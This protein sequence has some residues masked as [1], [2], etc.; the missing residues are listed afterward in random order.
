[1]RPPRSRAELTRVRPHA[2][3]FFP[4]WLD[5]VLPTPTQSLTLAELEESITRGG[6][7]LVESQKLSRLP[8]CFVAARKSP[9][10]LDSRPALAAT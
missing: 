8:D 4:N 1:M 2:V 9:S 5:R 7:S 10:R 3:W 6:F